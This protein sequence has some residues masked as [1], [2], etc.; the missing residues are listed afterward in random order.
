[1][2][3][4]RDTPFRIALRL[5]T[6]AAL[7]LA[8]TAGAVD[9]FGR[10]FPLRDQEKLKLE[11]PVSWFHEIR[12]GSAGAPPTI[13]FKTKSPDSFLVL[14]TPIDPSRETVA[15]ASDASIRRQVEDSARKAEPSSVEKKLEVMELRG[16]SGR[17][18]Y[19][20]ATDPSPRPG[21]W[22]Y[23]TQ[24]ILRVGELAIS[25]TI[26]TNEGQ[27]DVINDALRMLRNAKHLKFST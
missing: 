10:L 8:A 15:A 12:Q 9:T 21:T 16:A 5:A 25:F 26:L 19:F 2:T 3:R 11:V 17:G 6:A 20:F 22:K 27:K 1:V 4:R 14:L 13:L 24:G 18:Y 7:C 23:M